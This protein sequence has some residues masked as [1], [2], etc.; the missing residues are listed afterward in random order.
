MRLGAGTAAQVAEIAPL[1]VILG[2]CFGLIGTLATI[3]LTSGRVARAVW[4]SAITVTAVAV[5]QLSVAA[6][7]P[8]ILHV[9]AMTVATALVT[10][11]ALACSKQLVGIALPLIEVTKILVACGVMALALTLLA[12]VHLPFSPIPEIIGGGGA[13]LAAARTLSCRSVLGLI[14]MPSGHAS[15]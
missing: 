14:R 7:S 2:G 10:V 5:A 11:A 6:Q 15:K 8:L 9:Q 1:S 4:I 12:R 3:A 13:F